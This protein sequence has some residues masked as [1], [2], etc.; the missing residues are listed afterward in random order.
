MYHGYAFLLYNDVIVLYR[1][2]YVNTE[3]QKNHA[4]N[5]AVNTSCTSGKE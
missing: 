2:F 3:I 5:T 4:Q 1:F